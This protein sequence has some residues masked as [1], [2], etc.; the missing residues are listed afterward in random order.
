MNL[1]EKDI[2]NLI[3]E[4]S[5]NYTIYRKL[6]RAIIAADAAAEPKCPTPTMFD[7]LKRRIDELAARVA[8]IEKVAFTHDLLNRVAKLESWAKAVRDAQ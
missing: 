4:H 5:K 8:K 3:L 7:T 1:T 6:A 2:H